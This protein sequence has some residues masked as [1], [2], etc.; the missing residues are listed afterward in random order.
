[1]SKSLLTALAVAA[2]FLT[3]T[4]PARADVTVG[5]PADSG[6]GNC[7]PFSCSYVGEYQQVYS[8]TQFGRSITITSLDFYN[9]ALNTG[10]TALQSGN[11]AIS[12]STTGADWNTLSGVYANNIGTNNALV[13][14]GNLAQPW[15]FGDVLK[16]KLTTPFIYNPANGNLLL[17]VVASGVSQFGNGVFFDTNGLNNFGYNGNTFL[18]RVYTNSNVNSGYGLVT[19]FSAVPEPGFAG[20]VALALTGMGIAIRRRRSS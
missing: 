15:A 3:G 2:L 12:L 6:N 16:I 13:F 9:T 14:N 8:H 4:R 10:A 18:G 17:D 1:M 19:T 7:F 11:W 5:L 20:L